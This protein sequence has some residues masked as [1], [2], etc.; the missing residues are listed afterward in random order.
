[1]A[2][3]ILCQVPYLYFPES[4]PC[5]ESADLAH[6]LPRVLCFI[7]IGGNKLSHGD[8]PQRDLI[9]SPRATLFNRAFRF[10]F[11][12]TALTVIISLPLGN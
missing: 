1:M 12:S 6:N 5:S 4:H 8:T 3:T 7:R 11:A 10:V 9:F 2:T